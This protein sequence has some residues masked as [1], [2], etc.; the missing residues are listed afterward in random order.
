MASNLAIDFYFGQENTDT[1][2]ECRDLDSGVRLTLCI[3]GRKHRTRSTTVTMVLYTRGCKDGF[4]KMW[5]CTG[6]L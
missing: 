6:V 1:R 3:Q 4:V 5:I 2:A